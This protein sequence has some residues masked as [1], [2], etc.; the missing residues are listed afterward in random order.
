MP[1]EPTVV[2]RGR[3]GVGMFTHRGGDSAS[4]VICNDLHAAILPNADAAVGRTQIDTDRQLLG[5]HAC[6][7]SLREVVGPIEQ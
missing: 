4:L 2:G 5:G 6:S 1:P 3:R 7:R